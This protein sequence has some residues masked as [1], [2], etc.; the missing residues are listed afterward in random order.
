MGLSDIVF[1]GQY[2]DIQRLQN[3]DSYP[4]VAETNLAAAM[5]ARPIVS[6]DAEVR[7]YTP[8]FWTAY[9]VLHEYYRISNRF[10]LG[11][12]ELRRAM[13]AMLYS[14]D[15][16]WQYMAVY[17][18][19]MSKYFW[20]GRDIVKGRILLVRPEDF[21][22]TEGLNCVDFS[23][24]G[25][26]SR[27][28]AAEPDAASTRALFA[29]GPIYCNSSDD[30]AAVYR[31]LQRIGIPLERRLEDALTYRKDAAR[32]AGLRA[33]RERLLRALHEGLERERTKTFAWQSPFS[34]HCLDPPRSTVT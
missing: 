17:F 26:A 28:L 13:L 24:C 5:E 25:Y 2:A 10:F 30:V 23:R 32:I 18:E 34:A 15:F 9:P 14:E 3:F 12:H 1:F 21:D 19:I 8:A 29:E 22:Q 20:L 6:F 7:R 27:V 4:E 31:H 11:I 16:Y 33:F